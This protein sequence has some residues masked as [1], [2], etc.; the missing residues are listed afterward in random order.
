MIYSETPPNNHLN[1]K[2]TSILRPLFLTLNSPIEK[3]HIKKFQNKDHLNI[4]TILAHLK[5]GLISQKS[6]VPLYMH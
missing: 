6:G 3:S 5:G 4:V 2:T 1:I